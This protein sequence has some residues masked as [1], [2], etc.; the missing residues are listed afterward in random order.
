MVA[1]IFS[2]QQNG[3]GGVDYLFFTFTSA[4]PLTLKLSAVTFSLTLS[5]LTGGSASLF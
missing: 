2:Q 3:L 4:F 5:A 1:L